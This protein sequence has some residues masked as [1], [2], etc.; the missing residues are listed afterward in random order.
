MIC[1][2][3]DHARWHVFSFLV[4]CMVSY[5][6]AESDHESVQSTVEQLRIRITQLSKEL[7]TCQQNL[8]DAKS[9]VENGRFSSHAN[10]D[11]IEN[12]T[13]PTIFGRLYSALQSPFKML[14]F[15]L[16]WY[17]FTLVYFSIFI[18]VKIALRCMHHGNDAKGTETKK[19][20]TIYPDLANTR[21]VTKSTS[22]S[23]MS[24]ISEFTETLS[25]RFF[26]SVAA[27]QPATDVGVDATVNKNAKT[28]DTESVYMDTEDGVSH[29]GDDV[30]HIYTIEIKTADVLL[31]DMRC[32]H[33][34]SL[35]VPDCHKAAFVF[36]HIFVFD[37][38]III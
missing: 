32:S 33:P 37:L 15:D 2:K 5:S 1:N 38:F 22:F 3:A 19:S 4:A 25:S 13:T 10:N 29:H 30:D 8:V 31:G 12:I 6:V 36:V 16:S 21:Q 28:T 24:T 35:R 7:S 17:S 26:P 11:S 14:R 18:A 23:S 9:I 20:S 27:V 34:Q